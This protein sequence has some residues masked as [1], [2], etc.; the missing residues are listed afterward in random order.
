MLMTENLVL[1]S[2]VP[3]SAGK[4][5]HQYEDPS[6]APQ[7]PPNS[8]AWQHTLITSILVLE[9][10]GSWGWGGGGTHGYASLAEM[11]RIQ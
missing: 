5:L 8:K 7:H 4:A 2:P 10:R 9:T 6:L 1:A 3:G 11:A